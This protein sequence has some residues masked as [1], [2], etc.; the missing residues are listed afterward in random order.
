MKFGSVPIGEALGGVVA[1]NVRRPGIML[2]KGSIVEAADIAALRDAGVSD[3]IV[4][5]LDAGDVS[6][7]DAALALA[8]ALRGEGVRIDAPFTGRC[9]VFA[10]R[11]GL[12]M[13]DT[14]AVDAINDIDEGITFATLAAMRP[15]VAGEMVA[16]IKIIPFAVP[17][18]ALD[19]AIALSKPAQI[20]VRA[21]LPL[22]VG[23]VSTTLPGL[24]P[25]VIDKTLA[26]LAKRL[27]IAGAWIVQEERTP[28]EPVATAAAITRLMPV[29]DLII[30]FGASAV[31]DRRDVIPA[32]I[33]AAGGHIEHLGMPVDP[34]NLLLLGK[35][36][37]GMPIIGAPGCARSPKENG[38]DFVLH[39]LLAGV[40]VVSR[41]IRRMGVGGLL[42]EIVS[43]P[44]PREGGDAEPEPDE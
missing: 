43:R 2:K 30:L 34:G 18:N 23:V 19:Q 4:A 13:I 22:R 37:D 39:R 1:H 31:M 16:T 3:I 35:S 5:L 28:H 33:V 9:N 17:R 21:F 40:P 14:P 42:M 12:L 11:A 20:N 10:E 24:K 25:A 8:R 38:F 15:V 36:V 26:V 7:N 6:E 29:C 44:Q 41:D 32:A 27:S